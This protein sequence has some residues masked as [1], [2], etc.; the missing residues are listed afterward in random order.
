M[1]KKLRIKFIMKV[2]LAIALIVGVY[3]VYAGI[4]DYYYEKDLAEVVS[5]LDSQ[6]PGWE[7]DRRFATL[8][9]LTKEENAAE[10]IKAIM[11]LLTLDEY[12]ALLGTNAWSGEFNRFELNAFAEANREFLKDHPN[13][14]LPAFNRD[15]MAKLLSTSPAPEGLER[16]RRLNRF[17]DGL[18]QHRYRPFLAMSGLSDVQAVRNLVRLLCFHASM[19]MEANRTEQAAED[20]STMLQV[21]RV[22]DHDPFQI[23]MLVRSAL[24]Q[25]ASHSTHRLLAQSA[26]ISANTLKRLQEEFL[27][28][29]TLAASL[30]ELFRWERALHDH[31]LKLLHQGEYRLEQ[32]LEQYGNLYI[33]GPTITS[34]PWLDTLLKR[35]YPSLV[36]WLVG[37]ATTLR[38]R[39]NGTAEVLWQSDC[40]GRIP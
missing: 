38:G 35:T 23:C 32:F 26:T 25:M 6:E 10:E 20:I 19:E 30:P 33:M 11:R 5:R 2:V 29:E 36:L 8:P 9:K 28:E 13:A 31:D 37:H 22:F 16:A 7:W 4:R 34:W 3:Y 40:L 18:F 24:I 27:R 1:L 39:A 14:R 21:A 15:T 12:R 17:S